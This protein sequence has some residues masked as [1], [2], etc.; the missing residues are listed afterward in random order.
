MSA[1]AMKK[2]EKKQSA[3]VILFYMGITFIL[4]DVLIAIL[5][6]ITPSWSFLTTNVMGS[7]IYFL[8]LTGICFSLQSMIKTSGIDKKLIKNW[9]FSLIA[10]SII[11]G[12]VLGAYIW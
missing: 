2:S 4:V 6:L 7:L 12:I 1:I 10:I 5:T 3:E 11:L 9:F 8:I